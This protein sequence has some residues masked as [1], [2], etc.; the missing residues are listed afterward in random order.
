MRYLRLVVIFLTLNVLAYREAAG[1]DLFVNNLAGDDLSDGGAPQ[2]MGAGRGPV[3]TLRQALWLANAGDHISLTNT[4]TPYRESVTLFGAKHSGVSTHPFVIDGNGAILDGSAPIPVDAW[5][6]D[7]DDVFRFRPERMAYQQLFLDGRPAARRNLASALAGPPE[8]QPLEWAL[9][10]GEIY[11]RVEPGRLPDHYHPSDAQLTVGLT[12]YKVEYV[13]IANLV[14][15]GFQLDGINLQDTRSPCIVTQCTA[16]GNGRSGIAVCGASRA[17][18]DAC[19]VGNNGQSQLHIEGPSETRVENCDLL[20]NT[21]PQWLKEA[22]SR[23]WVDG[24][25]E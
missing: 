16:R 25:A 19:L 13:T 1:R 23:L 9:F 22:A 15:Q 21:G 8:L 17:T 5:Q 2:S 6:H 10:D 3:Q 12:L 7:H 20:P 11:F 4:G 24:K 14:V 18:V